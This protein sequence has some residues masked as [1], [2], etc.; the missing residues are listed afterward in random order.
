MV[1]AQIVVRALEPADGA[2]AVRIAN[3]TIYGLKPAV[4]TADVERA[5]EVA[6][7][8]TVNDVV[9]SIAAEEEHARHFH[10]ARAHELDVGLSRGVAVLEGALLLRLAPENFVVTIGIERRINV[11][12]VY[13]VRRELLQLLQVVAAVDDPRVQER[14]G[15]ACCSCSHNC[16]L[17][18][19]KTPPLDSRKEPETG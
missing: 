19:T 12:E 16:P 8:S 5:R 11:N 17:G 15:L 4:F 2:D 7:G 1:K 13:A 18:Y 14:G 6:E 9:L 10:A 3:D